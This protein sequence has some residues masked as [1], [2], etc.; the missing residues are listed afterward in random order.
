MGNKQSSESLVKNISNQLYVNK[1]TINQLNEQIND[2]VANTIVKNAMNSGGAIINKQELKFKNLKAKG[3]IEIGGVSQK[4]QAAVTF[5]AMNKT[6]ARNDAATEFIQKALADLKNNVSQ[7]ILTKMNATA[8]AKLES[9]FLS[10]APLSSATSKS[11]TINESNITSITENTKNI[12]NILKNQVQNNFTTDT[13]TSCITNIN[14]SQLFEVQDVASDEGTIRILNISQ[15]QSVTAISKCSSISDSTNKIIAN[16][17][18]ALDV[19]VDETNSVVTK[20]EAT[21]KAT[22]STITKGPLDFLSD[23][24]SGWM[25]FI[26]IGIIGFIVL[27]VILIIVWKFVGSGPTGST[28]PTPSAPPLRGGGYMITSKLRR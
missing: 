24:M 11:E 16:T 6:T 10:Q 8:E 22:A 15:D 7:D 25:S 27:V 4:Q 26:V 28:L 21:G 12:S 5:S 13:V 3:D 17:L 19:K 18:N 20:T 14:N 2:V 1:S 23:L 9:G